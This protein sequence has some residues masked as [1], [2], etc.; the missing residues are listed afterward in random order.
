MY[1]SLTTGK[2]IIDTAKDCTDISPEI[3]EGMY[4]LWLNTLLGRIYASD[5]YSCALIETDVITD[6]EVSYFELSSLCGEGRAAVRECDIDIILSGG[7]AFARSDA[8]SVAVFRDRAQFYGE[9][10]RVY[11]YHPSGLGSK[12]TVIFR[13]MP[14]KFTVDNI[15]SQTLP[16]PEEH[17]EMPL[18]YLVGRAYEYANE[19]TQASKWLGAFNVALDA[20]IKWH[21]GRKGS[22]GGV[23]VNET[24]K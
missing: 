4:I 21:D 11:L 19:D 1:E 8:A 10:G 5:V 22:M 17:M 9:D 23:F 12:C 3:P 18:D 14:P 24:S 15:A 7:E 2:D 16:L 6:G 13:E 20:F